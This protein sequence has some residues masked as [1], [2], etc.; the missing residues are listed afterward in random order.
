MRRPVPATESG[1]SAI[2]FASALPLSFAFTGVAF[3]L[4]LLRLSLA[5]TTI[6]VI[7]VVDTDCSNGTLVDP[8]AVN[9]FRA[10]LDADDFLQLSRRTAVWMPL[11][12]DFFEAGDHG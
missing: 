9:H 8:A 5:A 7:V 6:V 11:H 1:K 3:L 2:D 10:G 12:F 4:V